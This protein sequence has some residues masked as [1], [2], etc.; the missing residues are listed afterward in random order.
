MYAIDAYRATISLTDTCLIIKPPDRP[1]K[2]KIFW[3]GQY[4]TGGS[5][6]GQQ[7]GGQSFVGTRYVVV[8]VV[9]ISGLRAAFCGRSEITS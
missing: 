5:V 2:A 1:Q 7:T 8:A 6:G 9:R 3:R 4:F